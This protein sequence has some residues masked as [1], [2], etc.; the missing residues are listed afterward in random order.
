MIT[1]GDFE[2]TTP[3]DF[4]CLVTPQPR[5]SVSVRTRRRLHTTDKWLV[6]LL[7]RSRRRERSEK[8]IEI[9]SLAF[10]RTDLLLYIQQY[11]KTYRLTS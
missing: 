5:P 9:K 11:M 10:I 6:A 4:E 2:D 8:Q 7:E 3:L 1:T